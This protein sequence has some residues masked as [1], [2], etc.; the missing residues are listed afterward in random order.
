MT[1]DIPWV[2]NSRAGYWCFN[3]GFRV[4][5][6]DKGDHV[7]RAAGVQAGPLN[8]RSTNSPRPSRGAQSSQQARLWCRSYVPNKTKLFRS[9]AARAGNPSRPA[10]AAQPRQDVLGTPA[11]AAS[12]GCVTVPAQS[13]RSQP[14]ELGSCRWLTAIH[15]VIYVQAAHRNAHKG[16]HAK[17]QGVQSGSARCGSA[18]TAV[19]GPCPR[20][21]TRRPQLARSCATLLPT[22]C[23]L[24]RCRP[25]LQGA[26]VCQ[27]GT[28][29]VQSLHTSVK[30]EQHT[31]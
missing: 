4:P 14:L 2:R 6:L 8:L 25:S 5:R 20:L 29:C 7:S 30:P 28:T 31:W 1:T 11:Q 22:E 21:R 23:L 12:A 9:G 15:L 17:A 3:Q 18:H 24:C 10:P 27:P 19:H 13:S 26:A 16:A